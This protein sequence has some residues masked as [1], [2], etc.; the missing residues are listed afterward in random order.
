MSA[1]PTA[2]NDRHVACGAK[3][4]DFAGY[5]MPI[6]YGSM[7]EEHMAVRRK[8]GVFD[9][10]HMGEFF[11]EGPD[12]EA[13]LDSV[14]VNN[15]ASLAHGQ[16]QYSAL[17]TPEGGIVDDLLVHRIDDTH[18]MLV[19]NASNRHK[20]WAWLNEHK[21][22]DVTLTDRSDEYSLLACQGREAYQV[23]LELADQDLSDL[24]YY[25]FR[26]G[27]LQGIPL[28]LAR[29]GY[30]GERGFELYVKNEQALALW[31]IVMPEMEKRGIGPVGLGARDSLR[32]EMKFALYGNDIDDTTSTLEAD[33]GWITKLKKGRDFLGRELLL[34]QKAQGLKRRLLGFEMTGRGIAR[35]GQACYLGETR[36]GTVTSGGHSPVLGKAI[37]M[38][39]I[40]LPH[41]TLELEFEVDL[42]GRRSSARVV[43]TPFVEL[44][45]PCR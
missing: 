11:V 4:V 23:V 2:L 19:V 41:D 40:D 43:R 8:G 22:G 42:N 34:S 45:V 30:T 12:A 36:I 10:S 15:V 16:V 5:R 14:T 38:A 3:M 44:E 7:L 1:K 26:M 25:W 13:F 35:H 21:Q 37:G 32:L 39:Y 9:V 24:P 18:F 27:S 31:D 28:I 17:P 29:T 20:D 33:L 6:Q